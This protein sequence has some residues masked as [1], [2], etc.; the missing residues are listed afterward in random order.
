MPP[1]STHRSAAAGSAAAVAGPTH[2]QPVRATK[3]PKKEESTTPL[4]HP[5]VIPPTP[6]G[7]LTPSLKRQKDKSFLHVQFEGNLTFT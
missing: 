3:K 4:Q 7:I 2:T 6:K 1:T 5:D